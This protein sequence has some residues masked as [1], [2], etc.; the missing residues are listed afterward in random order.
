MKFNHALV[1]IIASVALCSQAEAQLLNRIMGMGGCGSK[2]SC[3][4]TP[5][6]GPGCGTNAVA[7][8][9]DTGCNDGCDTGCGRRKLVDF[10]F[11]INW[12]AIPRPAFRL[13]SFGCGGCDTGCDSGCGAPA[14]PACGT[15]AV[16]AGC[17]DCGTKAAPSC[18]TNQPT[19]AGAP[20]AA[21]KASA[22]MQPTPKS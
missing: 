18:G 12:D 4:D 19:P 9:C 15:N 13:R 17:G 16:S 10:R 14:A 22:P 11:R 7:A 5:V 1:A 2:T 3:C 6:A 21:P 8:P 20:A